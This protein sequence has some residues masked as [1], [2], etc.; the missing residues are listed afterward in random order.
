MPIQARNEGAARP[1]G[2][3]PESQWDAPISDKTLDQVLTRTVSSLQKAFRDNCRVYA[4]ARVAGGAAPTPQHI[5]SAVGLTDRTDAFT[6]AYL[7]PNAGGY[8]PM[9]QGFD[10]PW[11]YIMLHSFGYSW[12]YYQLGVPQG[13]VGKRTNPPG[14]FKQRLTPPGDKYGHHPDRWMAGIRQLCGQIPPQPKSARVSVH[15]CISRRGDVVVSCDMNDVAYHGGGDLQISSRGNNYVTVG[16]ELEPALARATP[17]GPVSIVPFT[18]RQMLALAIVCKKISSAR[19]I[20]QTYISKKNGSVLAQI[21]SNP[22]GFIRHTDVFS[23]KVDASGQFDLLPGEKGT[24]GWLKNRIS[25][26]DQLWGLMNKL[27]SFDLATEVFTE[28]LPD[29]MAMTGRQLGQMMR[30]S[31][32]EGQRLIVQSSWDRQKSF[33]RAVS[34]Q[35]QTRKAHYRQALGQNATLNDIVGKV[36][37]QLT[38]L[39]GALSGVQVSEMSMNGEAMSFNFTTGT[40]FVGSTDTKQAI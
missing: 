28:T 3:P 29:V 6:W 21:A 25:G 35:A 14:G 8:K 22:S 11:S 1:Q 10:R 19:P 17:G 38:K 9:P 30:S 32:L 18:D 2:H 4:N 16:F 34:M 39:A 26:W 24:S 5:I 20:A 23:K 12:D 36:G 15:F 33:S 40:W 13:K 37:A 7:P 27:R 31:V